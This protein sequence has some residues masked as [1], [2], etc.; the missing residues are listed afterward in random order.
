M[1]RKASE[2]PGHH[3]CKPIPTVC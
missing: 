1:V 2:N 3:P